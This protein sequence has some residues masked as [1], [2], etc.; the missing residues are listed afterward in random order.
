MRGSAG[1]VKQAMRLNEADVKSP[2]RPP[3]AKKPLAV[4]DDLAGAL[5]RHRAA[6]ATFEA[7]SPSKR[8]EY[9]EWITEAKTDATRQRRLDTAIAWMAEGK[10]RHWKYLNC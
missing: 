7:F 3:K 5:R 6:R 1:Y 8:R 4:P 2:A 10:P 9:V